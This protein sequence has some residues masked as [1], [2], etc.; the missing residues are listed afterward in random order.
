MVLGERTG[1][2]ELERVRSVL[3]AQPLPPMTWLM[4]AR[5]R[6]PS[7]AQ[8]DAAAVLLALQPGARLGAGSILSFHMLNE[9]RPMRRQLDVLAYS[10][11]PQGHASDDSTVMENLAAIRDAASSARSFAC[12]SQVAIAP[13]RFMPRRG[14]AANNPRRSRDH[15]HASLFGAAWSCAAF[16]Q[17]ASAGVHLVTLAE[18]VGE[19]GVLPE[20][21]TPGR[22]VHP[23]FHVLAFLGQLAGSSVLLASIDQ[24]LRIAALAVR[25]ADRV[26]VLLANLRPETTTLDLVGLPGAVQQRELD[27]RSL[28]AALADPVAWLSAP[29]AS[30]APAAV[31]TLELLPYAVLRLQAR[32][33][34]G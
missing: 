33:A 23:L 14:E 11:N 24:P 25:Q 27:E 9:N 21:P 29:D 5:S 4:Q 30:L 31:H 32:S 20:Q 28:P 6:T 15:R 18:A 17:A 2:A 10:C 22:L 13:L 1:A 12:A 16:A 8:L 7:E 19:E 3:A 34:E 26:S